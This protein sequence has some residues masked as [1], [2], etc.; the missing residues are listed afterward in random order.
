[1]LARDPKTARIEVLGAASDE[2]HK[3]VKPLAL[4]QAVLTQSG[5]QR[6]HVEALCIGLGPGSYTGIRSAIALAQGW[7]LA[8]GIRTCGVSTVEALAFQAQ[9]AACIGQ[10]SVVIDAQRK[11]FYLATY[12]VTSDGRS[13]VEPLRLVDSKTLL[14]CANQPCSIVVGP[15]VTKWIEHGRIVLPEAASLGQLADPATNQVPAESL[16][17]IYLRETTFVKAPPPRPLPA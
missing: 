8:R 5:A 14:A 6:E 7:Q 11:E 3:S 1:L 13:V 16:E 15:E 10:V 9:A 17:P 2:G 12:E 4:I